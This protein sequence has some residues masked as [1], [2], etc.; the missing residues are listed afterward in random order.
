[1]TGGR[2]FC[3]KKVDRGTVPLSYYILRREKLR[4]RGMKNGGD[5]KDK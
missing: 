1:M 3:H 5:I 4:R 2:S